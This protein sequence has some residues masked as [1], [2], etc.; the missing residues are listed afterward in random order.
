MNLVDMSLADMIRVIA[1]A[2]AEEVLAAQHR[3]RTYTNDTLPVGLTRKAYLRHCKLGTWPAEKRGRL[4]VSLCGPVD[5]WLA[6]GQRAKL[7]DR[8]ALASVD[9]AGSR[10]S[11]EDIFRAKGMKPA[12]DPKPVKK[13][14]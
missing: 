7:S 14:A 4:W 12:R 6:R 3:Q 11:N 5:D 8:L 9:D 2:T 10:V 13:S 1:K